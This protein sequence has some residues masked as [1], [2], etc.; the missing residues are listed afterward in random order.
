MINKKKFSLAIAT[1]LPLMAAS[2]VA[3]SCVSAINQDARKVTLDVEGKADKYAK[4]VTE[5]DL[6]A[7][8]LDTTKYDLNVVKIT[9][10]GTKLVVEF[11]ITDKNSKAVSEKRTFEISGFKS[12]VEK[13]AK[14]ILDIKDEFYDELAEQKLNKVY[15]PSEE[16][17]KKIAEIATKYINKLEALDE[18]DLTPDSLAWARALK[19]D[20][21][22]L[23]GNHEKGLRYVFATFQWGAGSTYPMGGYSRGTLNAATQGE[24]AVK[25]LMEAIDLNLVPS[26]VYIKNV[27]ALALKSF[28]MN[29]IKEFMGTNKEEIKLSDLIKVSDKPQS[30]WSTKD[31]RN[32]FFHEYATTYYKASKYGFGENVEELKLTKKNDK[33]EVE[34]TIQ[35]VEKDKN[36]SVYGI[37]LTEKDLKQD[38][39]G[40]G[41]MPGTPGKITGKD[42]YDQL[43]KMNSTSNLTPNE[44]YKKGITSTQ[45][46]IDNMK[47]IASEVAKLIAGESGE[48]KAKYR[49][50]EDGVGPEEVK[51]VESVIRK[52]NGEI[53]IAEFN[54][55]LNAEDFFFGRE[56]S[57]YYSEEKIKEIDADKSL[58]KAREK[59]EGLGYS[60]LQKDTTKYGNITNKQ[61][62]Y[63]ALEA[64]KG[65]YQFKETT[66]KYGASFFGKEVPDYDVDTYD[67]SERERSGV[68]AYNS[69]TKNFYFNADPYYGLPKWS[70]TSF[71]NHESMMGHHNQLM[72][73]ENHIAK[74]GE[75]SLPNGTFRY[76][77]YVE[78]WALF[79]EWFGIEAG[80]YGTPDY[81]NNDY[82]AKP[83]DFTTAKG[84]TSFFKAKN[85]ND[86]T[87][88]EI[89]K[90]KDLHGGVYWSKVDPENKLSEKERAAKAVKL[91]NMLQYYGALNETQLRNMRL[92]IDSAY[93][94]DGVET[95]NPDLPRG[96]SIHQAREYMKKNSALGIGDITSDSRR[97]FGYVGQAISYN[98]GKEVF[99]DIYKA[100]QKKLGLTREQF[101]NAKTDAEGEHGE[102]KKLFDWFLRNSALPME[103]L[104]EVIYKAYGI[105]K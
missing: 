81:K 49:Y 80:F 48:W 18:N 40:L 77:S 70:V 28:Y 88:E 32:K 60:F 101:I 66:Q 96:A 38:K 98:S 19:Y 85:S 87:A 7:A 100:V 35:Y 3:I 104:R 47:A 86:V 94:S 54:K 39:V 52:Q 46:S 20:W 56:D 67:Y 22:I 76:T 90:I 92:A 65:Y 43:S 15:V 26:K 75:H 63:G 61:F 2:A 99:L 83:T 69:G 72:Y 12:A 57:T 17:S 37:G 13:V 103:T 25:N 8:N 93:H 5:K 79:M 45:S 91:V 31:W 16:Q 11:T 14:Q 9:P 74:I 27:L 23:K 51:E 44:V 102:I 82:Y 42:I 68:G 59:L 1:L 4:D 62:Y 55:W 58:D 24:Q 50:D 73:A 10:K 6:K 78:G 33:N 105:T 36:V 97:Y 89:K 95:A 29:E 34:N 41:F 30:E 71:A 84:I 64:F 53:D 21:E